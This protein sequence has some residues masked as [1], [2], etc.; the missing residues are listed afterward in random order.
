MNEQ[1]EQ[2]FLNDLRLSLAEAWMLLGRGSKDRKSPLH[3]PCIGTISPTGLPRQR[4]MIVRE[5]CKENRFLRFHTDN[6][7]DKVS[8]IADGASISV[9]GYHPGAKIQLRLSGTA[10]IE[11]DSPAAD[12]AWQETSLYGKRCYLA[13]PGPGTP[14]PGP[15]SGLSADLEGRKPGAEEVLP[16][17]SNFAILLAEIDKIEWLYLAHTGHRRARFSWDEETDNWNGEW[18]VP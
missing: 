6:R 14:S 12:K 17:R 13:N 7:T 11:T 16:G 18:L 3:M 9:L 5:V 1:S 4:I 10:R 15:I 8:D 2:S